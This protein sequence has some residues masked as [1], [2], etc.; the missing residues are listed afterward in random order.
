MFLFNDLINFK[1]QSYEWDPKYYLRF[2][3]DR[4]NKFFTPHIKSDYD[5]DDFQKFST[6]I[7]SHKLINRKIISKFFRF[8][9]KA[10]ICDTIDVSLKPSS[11]FDFLSFKSYKSSSHFFLSDN[12]KDAIFFNSFNKTFNGIVEMLHYNSRVRFPKRFVFLKRDESS[13]NSFF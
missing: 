4:V 12:F 9:L 11:E 1:Y 10:E 8:F 2:K 5:V 3:Q 6:L 13:L 7:N